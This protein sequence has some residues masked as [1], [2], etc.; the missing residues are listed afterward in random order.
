MSDEVDEDVVFEGSPIFKHL[1]EIGYTDFEAEA[2]RSN[3]LA[4]F[5]EEAPNIK[6][7]FFGSFGAALRLLCS[8]VTKT[9]KTKE[10][11][12]RE[13]IRCVADSK[14]INYSDQLLLEHFLPE[15][16]CILDHDSHNV[17]SF[18]K[19]PQSLASIAA[20]GC[21]P[22]G[23]VISNSLLL[24]CSS[25]AIWSS[26]FALSS[27]IVWCLLQDLQSLFQVCCRTDRLKEL[28]A[29]LQEACQISSKSLRLLQE[30]DLISRGFVLAQ[31]SSA[32]KNDEASE[33]PPCT[34][35]RHALEG[36][37]G[38]LS[39]LL[40][41]LHTQLAPRAKNYPILVG[42][43]SDQER[44]DLQAYDKNPK[45][46]LKH[47][48]E[49]A[50]LAKLQTSTIL[51]ELILIIENPTQMEIFEKDLIS[52][53]QLMQVKQS[54]NDL[55]NHLEY[56]RVYWLHSRNEEEKR[57]TS[58]NKKN[59]VYLALHS[60]S[61]HMHA[62]LYKVQNL[63]N[64]FQIEDDETA[65]ITELQKDD[66]DSLPP[67]EDVKQQLQLIKAELDSCQGCWEEA[68]ARVDQKYCVKSEDALDK[69]SGY[70]FDKNTS[71]SQVLETKKIP[72][73]LSEI[74]EPVAEDEVF[75]AFIEEE[76]SAKL[77]KAEYDDSIWSADA[78]KR[79]HEMKHQRKQGKLVLNELQ[80]ILKQ[81]REMWEKREIAVLKRKQDSCLA[82]TVATNEME[83]SSE[84]DDVKKE[85]KEL[86]E[87][88]G[89]IRVQSST[90][91]NGNFLEITEKEHGKH[92][93]GTDTEPEVDSDE[94]RLKV[95]KRVKQEL[96]EYEA[97]WPSER[98]TP[99]SSDQAGNVEL[100][101]GK[102]FE[103]NTSE[104]PNKCVMVADEKEVIHENTVEN[105]EC[106]D[107][108]WSASQLPSRHLETLDERIHFMSGAQQFGMHAGIAAEAQE[109]SKKFRL[110]AINPIATFGGEGECEAYGDDDSDD[111]E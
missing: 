42:L 51:T 85:H 44:L 106:V 48:K 89:Q 15:G 108:N 72:I 74:D 109:F 75:E 64:K 58:E 107:I 19:W 45:Y 2:S 99:V 26:V 24:F 12:K 66:L 69:I 67:Y 110:A 5:S 76:Y 105:S 71:E 32:F 13:I 46:H 95:Y 4:E 81:R 54:V 86:P 91:G 31:G 52:V 7:S 50:N 3:S 11:L 34:S 104:L 17:P 65:C 39:R 29:V 92:W 40:C 1:Q 10:R 22:I 83:P 70:I 79:K 49:A 53:R 18:S 25:I 62:F 100:E 28:I 84:K 102:C 61:L 38:T 57:Q 73:V 87:S 93:L 97:S 55:S 56:T 68:V 80:P 101:L 35:L 27:P 59:C 94:E 111:S 14:L 37:L 47:L 36:M 88:T 23:L 77:D 41:E 78:K 9:N 103:T 82:D 43:F 33:S 60:L 16:K 6:K 21:I 96:D 30:V 20:V 98:A 63:E 8:S 90:K